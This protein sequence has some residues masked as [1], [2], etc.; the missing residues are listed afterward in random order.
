M[1]SVFHPPRPVP[2]EIDGDLKEPCF[3]LCH[4]PIFPLRPHHPEKCLL[5][6]AFG[7]GRI[8][9]QAMDEVEEGLLVAAIKRLESGRVSVTVPEHEFLVPPPCGHRAPSYAL[10]HLNARVA[11]GVATSS[12]PLYRPDFDLMISPGSP[13]FQH[14]TES[15]HSLSPSGNRRSWSARTSPDEERDRLTCSF[16]L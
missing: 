2:A 5:E 14:L 4:R 10:T 9:D 15:S 3:E 11:P 8:R 1:S 16:S 13:L 6:Q 12:V 7:V